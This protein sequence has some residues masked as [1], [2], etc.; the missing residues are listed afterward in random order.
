M[1]KRFKKIFVEITNRCNLSCSFCHNTNRIKKDMSLNDF[2]KVIEKIKDYTDYVY[3][4]VK[5]ESLLHNSLKEIIDICKNN[6]IYINITTNGTLIDRYVDILK[7]VRE[8][9]ISLHSENNMEGYIE[10]VISSC[11]E[12]SKNTYISYRLW[13]L[14]NYELD[15]RGKEIIDV[16][17][18]EYKLDY[19]TIEKL[20][21]DNSIKIDNNTFVDKNNL[22]TWP[23]SNNNLEEDGFCY[24]LT[25]HIG[26]LVDGT[27]VPCCLDGEGSIKLGNIFNESLDEILNNKRTKKMLESF[28]NGKRVEA[29]CKNCTFKNRI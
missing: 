2:E 3:L 28:K 17:I 8:L 13:T 23:D 12:I 11:K 18:K 10:K 16:L 20:K 25:T 26:I 27:V 15:E 21:K 7:D 29:L 9:N 5:G 24:G 4:H 1:K 22:F 6:N 14:N 19:D